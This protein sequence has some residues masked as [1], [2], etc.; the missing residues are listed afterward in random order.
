MTSTSTPTPSSNNNNPNHNPQTNDLTDFQSQSQSQSLDNNPNAPTNNTNSAVNTA[1]AAA[2]AAAAAAVAAGGGYTG[3]SANPSDNQLAGLVEAATAAAG[4]QDGNGGSGA[5]QGGYTGDEGGFGEGFGGAGRQLRGMQGMQGMQGMGGSGRGGKRKRGVGGSGAGGVG[6]MDGTG[7]LDPA[8]MGD[9]GHGFEHLEGNNGNGG[10]GHGHAGSVGGSGGDGLDIRQFPPQ[11]SLADARL[12]GVHSAAALFRQR[13]STAK[14]YTRPP[15]SK[16]FSSLELSPENFLYLQAEAKAFM[17]DDNHPERRDCVGQRGRG[18]TEMVKLRLWN[19]VREFLESGN[20]DRFFGEHVVNE[21]MP[22]RQLIWPRDAQQVIS[23][24]IPLLRRMVTNER[25][26][27]Y[28]NETRRGGGGGGGGGTDEGGKRVKGGIQRD[29]QAHVQQGHAQPQNQQMSENLE[30]GFLDLLL[31]GYPTD[32]NTVSQSYNTYNTDL[33]LDNLGSISGLKHSDWLGL[34]G[35]VDSHYQVVHQGI[36]SAC[37][38]PCENY[39]VDRIIGSEAL[40]QAGWRIPGT[41]MVGRNEFATGITR[42]IHRIIRSNLTKREDQ[43][44][45]QPS[46]STPDEHHQNHQPNEPTTTTTTTTNT[47]NDFPQNNHPIT[48]RINILRHGK[49]I[50]PR[51]DLPADQCPDLISLRAKIHQSYHA[52]LPSPHTQNQNSTNNAGLVE[53]SLLDTLR[54]KVLLAEGL[55]DVRNDGEWMIALMAAGTV[56]WMDG[57]LRVVGEVDS[58]GGGGEDA[59][60]GGE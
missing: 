21:G 34:V 43:I 30:L 39:D 51:H 48:L 10:H 37:S 20:G 40:G 38:E 28:A 27:Q 47:T 18:D 55:V 45:A 44:Q 35:A 50:L 54:F 16:L 36:G 56:D 9:A 6:D 46:L 3:A 19:C 41:D 4:E 42:D 49:R 32:W 1:R 13:P 58:G 14:K 7:A 29:T 17:L 31:E 60:E 53:E 33:Q 23:L 15:M 59:L 5:W 52:H 26:R 12:A 8:I 24:V 25:Q 11:Q 57:E 2:A 22:P